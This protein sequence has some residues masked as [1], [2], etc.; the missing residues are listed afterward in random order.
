MTWYMTW[1]DLIW[2][3]MTW[4]DM[5]WHDMTWY[6][7]IWHKMTWH[8]MTWH[9]MTWLDMMWHNLAKTKLTPNQWQPKAQWTPTCLTALKLIL[10]TLASVILSLSLSVSFSYLTLLA[11]YC[12]SCGRIKILMVSNKNNRL[13]T[14]KKAF[15]FWVQVLFSERGKVERS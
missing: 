9:D 7:M 5:I 2:H 10:G 4:Y 13:L 12:N 6:D 15:K 14:L 3:D 8:D 11:H 1:Y